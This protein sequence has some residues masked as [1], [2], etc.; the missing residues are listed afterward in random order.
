VKPLRI[1][2]VGT[3]TVGTW[4]ARAP[5]SQR[6]RLA[7]SYGLDAMVVGAASARG[8]FVYDANG[9]DLASLPAAARGSRPA[10]GGRG[11]GRWPATIEGLFEG[12]DTVAKVMI[13]SGSVTARVRPE[14]TGRDDPLVNV[15]GTTNAVV[16]EADPVG[17]VTITGPGAGPQLAGLGVLS[18]IIAVASRRAEGA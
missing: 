13:L 16:F 10:A 14:F 12:D 18:D 11:V 3:G 1:W 6:E 2:L 8:G 17:R 7:T 15:D 5:G 4:L 9:L